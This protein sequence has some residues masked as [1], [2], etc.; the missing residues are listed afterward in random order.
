AP[1]LALHRLRKFSRFRLSILPEQTNDLAATTIAPAL[2]PIA[3]R[4]G[5]QTTPAC[6]GN[7]RQ[8]GLDQRQQLAIFSVSRQPVHMARQPRQCFSTG[9]YKFV[10]EE[11]KQRPEEDDQKRRVLGREGAVRRKRDTR[12]YR[13]KHAGTRPL[14]H[15]QE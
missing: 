10:D 5:W 14:K 6:A 7:R 8:E 3:Q 15:V 12:T 9:T 4:L 11:S 2:E 13:S 1:D